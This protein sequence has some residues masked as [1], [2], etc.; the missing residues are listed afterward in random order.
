MRNLPMSRQMRQTVDVALVAIATEGLMTQ[1]DSPQ[2]ASIVSA[3][4]S[5]VLR[6]RRARLAPE[7]RLQL[8]SIMDSLGLNDEAKKMEDKLAQ[9]QP[10]FSGMSRNYGAAVSG[11][12]SKN[13]VRE[14]IDS[15]N[16]DTATR[17]LV[18]QFKGFV[19]NA[20]NLDYM[21]R[22]EDYQIQ[23]LF[24]QIKSFGVTNEFLEQLN[25]GSD[26]SAL[27]SS[28]YAVALEK[29]GKESEAIE[30][31]KKIV[32]THKRQNGQRLRLMMLEL[33][34]GLELT[35]GLN[36]FDNK[37]MPKVGQVLAAATQYDEF[38][39]ETKFKL[40]EMICDY[41]SANPKS[42][43]DMSWLSQI[44]Q[45]LSG[46][47]QTPSNDYLQPLYIIQDEDDEEKKILRRVNNKKEYL[48]FRQRR[49]E[50]HDQ[51][52][53]VLLKAPQ[54]APAA[55]T[56]LLQSA[57]ASNEQNLERFA[58]LAIDAMLLFEPPKRSASAGYYQ[59]WG[60]RGYYSGYL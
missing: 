22:G 55:F 40:V 49:K 45:W 28:Q 33:K 58:P 42:K 14:L 32:Q 34:N 59:T 3:A 41:V 21:M 31:Y 37:S 9:N 44:T 47:V 51:F 27:K 26:S 16:T 56:A 46:N 15:G 36:Q 29:I 24:R 48:D 11:S 12:G 38:D 52:A 13:R 23:E 10:S 8:V 30:V 5:A 2:N 53:S 20:V 35:N 54:Q 43:D 39:T 6:M 57:V 17:I 60:H 19:Q 18:N 4:K 7:Q 25:P 50:L 1:L